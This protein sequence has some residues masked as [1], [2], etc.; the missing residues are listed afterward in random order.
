MAPINTPI[1]PPIKLSVTASIKNW[2]KMSLHGLHAQVCAY[3]VLVVAAK[4]LHHLLGVQQQPTRIAVNQGQL[5]LHGL[6]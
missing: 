1:A 5:G 3:R 2:V 6:N 4:A